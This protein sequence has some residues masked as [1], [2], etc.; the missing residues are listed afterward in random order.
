[1]RSSARLSTVRWTLE[2][3]A[4]LATALKIEETD[5]QRLQV[6]ISIVTHILTPEMVWLGHWRPSGRRQEAGSA[7]R[8]VWR[9]NCCPVRTRPATTS[10]A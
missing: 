10:S 3:A 5:P 1:M 7:D 6:R 8:R 9:I 2:M 4:K